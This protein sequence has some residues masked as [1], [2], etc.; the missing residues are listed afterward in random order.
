M[1]NESLRPI[2]EMPKE[3]IANRIFNVRGLQVMLD[4]D[5]AELFELPVRRINEQMKRNPD[6]FPKDFCFELSEEEYLSLRS[7]IATFKQKT[8]D[9]GS[10]TGSKRGGSYALR[11]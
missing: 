8:S 9:R 11:Q 2:V 5:I 3:E 1:K 6:R 10:C 7:Q 4:S